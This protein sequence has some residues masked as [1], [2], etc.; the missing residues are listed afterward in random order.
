M[1]LNPI[2][3]AIP[4]FFLAIVVE[5]V[6]AGR[7]GL[8]AYRFVDSITDLSCGVGN[9]V[10]SLLFGAALL[11]VHQWVYDHYAFVR[12]DA[13]SPW[14]WIIAFVGVDFFYY[15]WHRFSHEVNFL[16]A[17]HIVHHQSEDYNLA[18]ALRQAYFTNFTAMPFYLPLALVGVPALPFAVSIAVS[19]AYQF[20]I[21]TELIKKLPAPVEYVFNTPAHH[22]VHH[23]TN[24]QYLDRN[25][26]AILIIWDR[27]FGTF[28]TEEEPCVYGITTPVGSFNPL[29]VNLHYWSDIADIV[30]RAPTWRRKLFAPFARPG[31]DPVTGV[32]DVP[33]H[34]PRE[35]FVKFDVEAPSRAMV[36]W[37]LVQ[38]S[39]VA[40]WLLALLMW[41]A[42]LPVSQLAVAGALIIVATV[43]WG[44]LFERR[45]W[46]P[47][48]EAARI[49]G[50]IAVVGWM[51]LA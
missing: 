34:V 5:L 51:V 21:H 9:Q 10:M 31:W 50:S 2:A 43:A 42:T 44:G 23:A 22:R 41:G 46:A 8:R 32:I 13:G 12:F 14:P 49:A 27:M 15:W 20:W 19:L 28:Q 16:W 37:V 17:A 30:R 36:A 39:L 18:V 11:A 1:E 40:V 29:W 47:A 6:L 33:V 45:K 4:I 24:T 48:L 3:L 25:Y 26:A 7:R 35:Q 38:F